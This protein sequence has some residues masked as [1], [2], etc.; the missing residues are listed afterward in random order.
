MAVLGCFDKPER[1]KSSAVLVVPGEFDAGLKRQARLPPT[2]RFVDG[3]VYYFCE[4]APF[5]IRGFYRQ[6]AE[7]NRIGR[8]LQI[9]ASNQRT[10]GEDDHKRFRFGL[11]PGV[12]GVIWRNEEGGS[13]RNSILAKHS[14]RRACNPG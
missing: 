3:D 4:N 2:P 1:F 6:L 12:S 5:S 8:F 13:I 11:D 9:T 7:I 10:L 14:R